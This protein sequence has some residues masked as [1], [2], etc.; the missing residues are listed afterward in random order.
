MP[1]EVEYR[2][3][4]DAKFTPESVKTILVNLGATHKESVLF[5]VTNLKDNHELRNK[6]KIRL[7]DEAS[8]KTFTIKTWKKMR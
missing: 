1:V 8:K 6:L 2:F 7:R 5:K 3:L 4:F